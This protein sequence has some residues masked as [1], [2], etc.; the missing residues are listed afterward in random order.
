MFREVFLLKQIDGHP[1]IV[2]LLAGCKVVNNLDLSVVFEN[3]ES[4]VH[5]FIRACI[6][7]DVHKRYVV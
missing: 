4:D 5:T 1:Y 2:E 7:M 6:L 3:L